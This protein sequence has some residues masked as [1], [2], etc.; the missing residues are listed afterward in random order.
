MRDKM[1]PIW[2]SMRS[3]A[4]NSMLAIAVLCTLL[5]IFW[6]AQNTFWPSTVFQD[7]KVVG[8]DTYRIGE[9]IRLSYTV[10]RYR[11]C[12]LE[13]GRYVRRS[14]DRREVLMQS[15]VQIIKAD[16]PPVGRPS[17]YV[18]E[19]PRG[20]LNP[21]ELRV[22]AD[23]FSRVQYFCNALDFLWPRIVDMEPVKIV[24]IK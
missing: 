12:K 10:T 16:N 6:W 22:E 1:R 21:D 3:I 18:A 13:I 15:V 11:S 7:P 5:V 8:S 2:S 14:L 23:V 17:G 4:G 24:I 9:Q 19:I 20:I